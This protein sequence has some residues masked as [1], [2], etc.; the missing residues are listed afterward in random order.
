VNVLLV[1]DDENKR[2]Q[3]AAAIRTQV[4]NAEVHEA[5]SLRSGRRELETEPHWDL[6]VLDMS[7]PAFDITRDESGGRPQALGGRDL[8]RHIRRL[9]LDVPVVVLTQYD[10]FGDADR[11]LT[12]EDL[13][14]LLRREHGPSYLGAIVYNVVFDS[15][16]EVFATTIARILD[17]DR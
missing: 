16:R 6:V 12:L 3:V 5:R 4:P 14:D 2:R 15:W 8:L 1:E 7:I 11:T 10:A 17:K 9:G 13:N